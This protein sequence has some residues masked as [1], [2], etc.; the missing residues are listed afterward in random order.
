[1]ECYDDAPQRSRL[2][3]G[4]EELIYWLE[5]L[6][7]RKWREDDWWCQVCTRV[8]VGE[9]GRQLWQCSA[10][11]SSCLSSMCTLLSLQPEYFSSHSRMPRTCTHAEYGVIMCHFCLQWPLKDL[12]E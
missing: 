1:M 2:G 7:E 6:R 12:P 10:P 9:V 11:V 5:I 3:G 4:D 8:Q